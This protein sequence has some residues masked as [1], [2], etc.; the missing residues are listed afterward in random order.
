MRS[1][2]RAGQTC[3][4]PCGG[5]VAA[6][7]APHPPIWLLFTERHETSFSPFVQLCFRHDHSPVNSKPRTGVDLRIESLEFRFGQ[8]H[9]GSSTTAK[10]HGLLKSWC[11]TGQRIGQ[12]RGIVNGSS[13]SELVALV[14]YKSD[15]IARSV[16]PGTGW[17]LFLATPHSN[18]LDRRCRA[19]NPIVRAPR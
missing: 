11:R 6:D 2:P 14:G 12:A 13:V 4:S 8:L 15:C 7:R 3:G 16:H 5:C 19:A 9:R 17:N 10:A 1:L 18:A